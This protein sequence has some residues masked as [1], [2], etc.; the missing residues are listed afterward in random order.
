MTRM[1]AFDESLS[2]KE[3]VHRI[4]EK[5]SRKEIK[6][7]RHYMAATDRMIRAVNGNKDYGDGFIGEIQNLLEEIENL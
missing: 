3:V 4:K 6:E 5:F 2:S 7:N 1:N